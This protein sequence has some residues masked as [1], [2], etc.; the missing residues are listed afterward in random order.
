MSGE[1]FESHSKRNINPKAWIIGVAALILLAGSAYVVYLFSIPVGPTP[2]EILTVEVR[3]ST[4]MLLDYGS[5]SGDEFR[6][7]VLG[8]GRLERYIKVNDEAFFTYPQV[9]DQ[10][11]ADFISKS[12]Y[13]ITKIDHGAE[14]NGE[15]WLGDYHAPVS[16]EMGHFFRTNLANI[17]VDPRQNLSF[18]FNEVN[19]NPSLAE[20]KDLTNNSQIYGGRMITQVP[21]RSFKSAMVFANHGIMVAKPGEPSLKRLA[22]DILKDSGPDRETRVQKLVDFVSAEIEYSYTEALS[23]RETLKRADETL[24][25]RSGDCSNKTI[26]LAS[27]LEQIGEPYIL[28]YCPRHITVAV[29]QGNYANENKLDFLWNDKPWLIAETTLPGFQLGKTKVNDA[30]LL[31][32]VE[33]VQDPK[34]ADVIFDANSYEVLKFL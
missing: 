15:I 11:F 13:D 29:P 24:M 8:K 34:N 27:L 28:L 9:P 14:K 4:V 16:A 1:L 10:E 33:Y 26:L 20:I 7:Q 30:R 17:R 2:N 5:F 12:F 6:R 23:R 22:G 3:A 18:A 32:H 25:T 31:T 21:E 19:Y